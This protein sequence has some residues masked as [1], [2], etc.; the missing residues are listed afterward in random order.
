VN[1]AGVSPLAI[2][3]A[4]VLAVLLFGIV[5]GF[6][7]RIVVFR[8]LHDLGLCFA[9]P[10]VPV[11]LIFAGI[12]FGFIDKKMSS[13]ATV[14]FWSLLVLACFLGLLALIIVR[15]WQDNRGILATLL[16]LV[17]KLPLG[18][19]FLVALIDFVAP[20]GNAR[21]RAEKRQFALMALLI[22][23]PLVYGLTRD[24]SGLS[25]SPIARFG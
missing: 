12:V 16:S 15:T 21:Q 4:L 5:Q 19:L 18:L 22:L 9:L 7:E 3:A 25:R 1:E 8:D 10:A 17:T 6:R 24:K 13:A 11:G 20:K 23:S 2:T 14:T